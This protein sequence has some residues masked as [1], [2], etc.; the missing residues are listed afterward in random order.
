VKW[1]REGDQSNRYFHM[2]VRWLPK[3]DR[4]KKLKDADG[5]WVD[6]A[7]TSEQII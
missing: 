7:E 2:K 6:N 3:K 1:L 4:T 5:N